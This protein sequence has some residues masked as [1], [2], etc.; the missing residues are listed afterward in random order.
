MSKMDFLFSTSSQ[1]SGTPGDGGTEGVT[2]A[3]GGLLQKGSQQESGLQ[4]WRW[5]PKTG[6]PR[7]DEESRGQQ[8]EAE[9]S[10][11]RKPRTSF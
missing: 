4:P 1:T 8:S 10:E 7:K 2:Q 9:E 11:G 6:S 5:G 3:R